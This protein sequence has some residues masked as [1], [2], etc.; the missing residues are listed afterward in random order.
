MA[1]DLD[2]DVDPMDDEDGPDFF[3]DFLDNTEDK[4]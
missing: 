1:D 3:E 2:P 4:A